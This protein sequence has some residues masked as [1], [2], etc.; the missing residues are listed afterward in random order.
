VG[1]W[2]MAVQWLAA[3]ALGGAA[4][5]FGGRGAIGGQTLLLCPSFSPRG[6]APA[7]SWARAARGGGGVQ[8]I[9]SIAW[10]PEGNYL[11][12]GSFDGQVYIWN[13]R[14]GGTVARA[15]KVWPG[16]GCALGVGAA[17]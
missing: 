13:M 3:A 9:Y 2:G 1:L 8:N 6:S 14:N 12:S 5:R 4:A 11:A 15:F 7:E 10:S 16:C 17:G